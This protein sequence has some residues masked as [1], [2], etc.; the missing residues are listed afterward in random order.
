M[1]QETLEALKANLRDVHL[2]PEIS[3]WPWA[4][5]WWVLLAVLTASLFYILLFTLEYRRRHRYKKS[6]L[7]QLKNHFSTWKKTENSETYATN[8]NQILRRCCAQ[9]H[10]ENTQMSQ[11]ETPFLNALDSGSTFTLSDNAIAALLKER[12]KPEPNINVEELH[13]EVSSWIKKA[14]P[15]QSRRKFSNILRLFSKE[16]KHD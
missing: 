3:W 15:E 10:S 13:Q 4:P 6:A 14:K 7:T 16:H 11:L 12:H 5:I 2:P 1:N 8:A 9:V